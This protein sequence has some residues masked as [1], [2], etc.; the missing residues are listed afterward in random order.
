MLKIKYL[1][2]LYFKKMQ[3]VCNHINWSHPCKSTKFT[4][5]TCSINSESNSFDKLIKMFN[6]A[7]QFT[8]Y[9]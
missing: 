8:H 6:V 7:N 9:E 4:L 2:N 5:V 3:L 1:N